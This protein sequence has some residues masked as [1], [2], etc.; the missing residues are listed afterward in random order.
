MSDT[1]RRTI[2]W[3]PRGARV[4]EL[5]CACGDVGAILQRDKACSVLGVEVDAAAAAEARENGLEVLGASLEDPATLDAIAARGPFDVV[6]ATDVLEHLRDPE[7]VVAALSRFV[8]PRGLAIVAVP[9]VATWS[10]R[11]RLLTRG[12]WDYAEDGLLDRT[13]LRF[14]TWDTI[15]RLV[16]QHGWRVTDRVIDGYEIPGASL[17]LGRVPETLRARVTHWPSAPPGVRR[18]LLLQ[19]NLA[20][21]SL[22]RARQRLHRA[23]LARVPNLVAPHVGLLLERAP[24]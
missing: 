11:W 18:E 3:V 10:S 22:I 19:A 7:P 6:L 13:H 20:L 1:H 4:L 16:E 15:H 9:N 8:G 12:T 24:S 17:V 23:L 5:G 21:D 2:D 14:F